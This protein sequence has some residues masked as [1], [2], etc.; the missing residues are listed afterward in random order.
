M[1]TDSHFR[2]ILLPVMIGLF[3]AGLSLFRAEPAWAGKTGELLLAPPVMFELNQLLKASDALHKS[4]LSQ[5]DEQIEMGIRDILLQIDK[6][7]AA[8]VQVKPHE[9]G[10]LLRILDS[11]HE[12]LELSRTSFGEQRRLHLEDGFNQLV[13]IVRIYRVDR[14]YGIFFC[15][16]DRTTWVQT[17]QNPKNPFR[18][19]AEGARREPCGIRVPR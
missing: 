8:S 1:R 13:N 19:M 9:R 10:H 12:Q 2:T 6:T 4:L 18:T 3:V 11:A 16:K 7:K 17:G 15:P 14:Q 5:D